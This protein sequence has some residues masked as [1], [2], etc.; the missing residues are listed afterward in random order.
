M[1]SEKLYNMLVYI[2][3]WDKP[4]DEKLRRMA[5]ILAVKQ[6]WRVLNNPSLLLSTIYMY[7]KL[8]D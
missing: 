2:A 3:T 8:K 5:N 6:T 7:K 4:D 1:T